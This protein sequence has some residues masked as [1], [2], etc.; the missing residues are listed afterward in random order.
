[1]SACS[2][3]T[4]FSFNKHSPCKANHLQLFFRRARRANINIMKVNLLLCGG[5]SYKFRELSNAI[6]KKH[7]TKYSKPF[8][9]KH[10]GGPK[11]QTTTPPFCI[12]KSSNILK[13][14]CSER[15]GGAE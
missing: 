3:M 10:V 5:H 14:S 13:D 1:M 15:P 7:S 4:V 12:L 8:I 6:L 2:Q 11:G 9:N